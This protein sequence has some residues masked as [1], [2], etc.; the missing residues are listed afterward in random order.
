VPPADPRAEIRAVI[1]AYA[2]AVESQN[3]D[4]IKRVYPGM[5]G[6]QQHGWEQFFQTVRD[7][8]AQLSVAQADVANGTAEAQV[9]GTYSYLNSSTRTTERIPIS[10]HATLRREP[11]GWRISQVR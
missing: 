4:N 8:K 6:A 2:S 9:T 1:G 7:V 10:F 3:I 5:T 11:G